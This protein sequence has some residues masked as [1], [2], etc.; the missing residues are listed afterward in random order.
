MGRL[1]SG[2]RSGRAGWPDRT[3][4]GRFRTI[5]RIPTKSTPAEFKAGDFPRLVPKKSDFLASIRFHDLENIT[6]KHLHEAKFSEREAVCGLAV[7]L[8][9]LFQ[10]ADTFSG[11]WFFVRA[12][13]L[14]SRRCG[15]GC[16][17]GPGARSEA[18]RKRKQKDEY[19]RAWVDDGSRK[20]EGFVFQR[21]PFDEIVADMITESGVLRDANRGLCDDEF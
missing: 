7:Q 11:R 20:R 8:S 6:G 10:Y 5:R 19:V 13:Q 16:N 3:L 12:D 15:P 1:G 14:L 9:A 17:L 4:R 18:G 21:S 2:K